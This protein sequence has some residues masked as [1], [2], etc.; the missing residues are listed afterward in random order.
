MYSVEEIFNYETIITTAKIDYQIG[1]NL[2]HHNKD[3]SQISFISSDLAIWS[4][5]LS[6]N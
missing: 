3:I 2:K 5:E 1:H 4:S 6:R